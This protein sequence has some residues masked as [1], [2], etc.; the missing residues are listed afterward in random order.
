MVGICIRYVKFGFDN[1]VVRPYFL[2]MPRLSKDVLNPVPGD[3]SK[4]RAQGQLSEVVLAAQASLP[5]KWGEFSIFGF[6]DRLTGVEHTAIVHGNVSE[7][8]RCPVRLHSQCHTGDV[9]GSL[10]C[11]C[12]AQ[13]EY[14]LE[15]ISSVPFGAVLYLAQEGRGIGL[16]NKIRAYHLQDLGMDTV[17]ANLNLGFPSDA[18]RYG[19]ASDMINLLG[20]R[21]IEL[22]TNNPDKIDAL[23]ELGIVVERR[24]PVVIESNEH[25][26]NYLETKRNRMGH[27]I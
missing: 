4:S 26:S 12:Q 3:R 9:L 7:S 16:V 10:R 13:L 14:A 18:R 22:L 19:V 5:T 11:D 2:R 27:L 1:R 8:E 25:N 17:D 6:L 24:L 20:I 21:S 23:T 15:Y